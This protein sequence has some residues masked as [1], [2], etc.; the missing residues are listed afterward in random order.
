MPDYSG[1]SSVA[2][3]IETGDLA[4]IQATTPVKGQRAFLTGSKYRAIATVAGTWSYYYQNQRC[5]L[6]PSTGW[7]K[8]N[9]STW[10]TSHSPTGFAG[11]RRM[12]IPAAVAAGGTFER[13]AEPAD[14]TVTPWS[15]TFG[16][17]PNVATS[18]GNNGANNAPSAGLLLGGVDTWREV[19]SCSHGGGSANVRTL[20]VHRWSSPTVHNTNVAIPDIAINYTPI[21]W[22]AVSADG[23]NRYHW[24]RS[25][26]GVW[27]QVASVARGTG[28]TADEVGWGVQWSSSMT[29]AYDMML[30]SYEESTGSATPSGP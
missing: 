7:S 6:P 8:Y 19:I 20:N 3:G 5:V 2:G 11:G 25:P 17:V 12:T 9:A 15:V 29:Y 14:P 26:R 23:V 13:R 18:Q 22:F 1:P 4:T 21:Y 16:V 30:V 10:T 28:F 24:I 27:N